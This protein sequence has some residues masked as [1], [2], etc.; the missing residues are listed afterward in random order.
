MDISRLIYKKRYELYDVVVERNNLINELSLSEPIDGVNELRHLYKISNL[1]MD[2]TIKVFSS[3]RYNCFIEKNI[4]K[5]PVFK[6]ISNNKD[7]NFTIAAI[8]NQI[9]IQKD[10]LD[11]LK[12]LKIPFFLKRNR[13]NKLKDLLL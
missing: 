8:D 6:F 11:E 12:N 10:K 3:L 1:N 7:I 2:D 9:K 13:K 5:K 4:F